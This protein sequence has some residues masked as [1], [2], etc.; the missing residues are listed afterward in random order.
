M[1][2]QTKGKQTSGQ[3]VVRSLLNQDVKFI[4]GIPGGK[5]MPTFDVLYDEGPKFI[6][7]RHEQNAA[8]MAA[9]LGRLTGR[10]GVCLVTSGP[11]TS[12]FGARLAQGGSDVV[13]IAR[14]AH[15][16]ALS[17]RGLIVESKLGDVNLPKV[18]ATDDPSTL[19]IVDVVLMAVKLWDTEAAGHAETPLSSRQSAVTTWRRRQA[20]QRENQNPVRVLVPL[21]EFNITWSRHAR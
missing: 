19:G 18:Q 12:N 21:V 15:L 9:A 6:V 20:Q 8:F 11:G 2:T 1:T 4:F 17:E 5:I 3:L 14:G 16:A 7:C 13:F 10:L